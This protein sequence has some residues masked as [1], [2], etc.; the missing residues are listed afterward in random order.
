MFINWNCFFMLD[1][2]WKTVGVYV[3]GGWKLNSPNGK[4]HT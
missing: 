1:F 4:K 3:K 2:I